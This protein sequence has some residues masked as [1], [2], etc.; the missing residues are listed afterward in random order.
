MTP[1]RHSTS[2]L[3]MGRG[4]AVA[5]KTTEIRK[6]EQTVTE[7]QPV[8]SSAQAQADQKEI[9]T[10]TLNP[11]HLTIEEAVA[12]LPASY[13]QYFTKNPVRNILLF[14]GPPDVLSA[15]RNDLQL[16]DTLPPHILVDLLAVELSD[17]ANQ[18]LGLDWTYVE[19]HFGLFQPTG[20][21]IQTIWPRR[22]R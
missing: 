4:T 13:G 19:G 22:Y 20:R 17:E 5:Q 15:L 2:A 9:I 12:S 8:Q 3:S 11:L 16:I 21:A 14:K 7:K 18:K 10:T 6:P 1:L